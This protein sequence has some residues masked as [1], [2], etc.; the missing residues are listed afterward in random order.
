MK[1]V[2]LISGGSDGLGKAIATQLVQT[3]VVVIL[4]HNKERVQKAAEEIGC[5]FVCADVSNYTEVETAVQEVIAKYG[6]IDCLVNNAGFW[7]EGTLESNTPEDIAKALDVN[8]KGTIFLTKATLPYMRERKSGRIINVISQAGLYAKAERI[9][10][11]ASKWAITGFTDSLRL[12]VAPFNIS[13]CG[14]YPGAMK[15]NFF[16]KVGVTKDMSKYIELEEAV[17]ALQF[18]IETPESIC[19][20][21]LGIKLTGS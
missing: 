12:E 20:P 7:I 9:V 11:Y 21:E 13:V 10:Y 16:T 3:H 6:Q 8:T 17:R 15:T 2:I 5:D 14:F 1:K 4:A 18:I 19:I